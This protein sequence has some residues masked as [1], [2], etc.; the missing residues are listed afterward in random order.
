MVKSFKY[1]SNDIGFRSNKV[2]SRGENAGVCPKSNNEGPRSENSCNSYNIVSAPIGCISP[3][4]CSRSKSFKS[5]IGSKS[6]SDC[7]GFMVLITSL[8]I[9]TYLKGM[10]C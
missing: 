7:I 3:V 2:G 8:T 1:G 4:N 5:C 9:L 6:C 10:A